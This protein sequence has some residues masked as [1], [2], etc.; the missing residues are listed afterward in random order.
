MDILVLGFKT[1]YANGKE[2]EW[3]QFTAKGAMNEVGHPMHSTWERVK[4]LIPTGETAEGGGG[5]SGAAMRANWAAIEPHYLAWK[6]GSEIPDTGTP[7]AAW[8]GVTADQAAALKRVGL[9]TVDDVAALP[10]ALLAKPPLPNMR[11]LQT[12]AKAYID[13]QGSAAMAETIAKQQAQIDA[14]LEMLAEQTKPDESTDEPE[15]RGPGRPRKEA[16]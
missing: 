12:M 7:L 1:D 14:M 11:E 8:S 6:E 9:R 16:A 4:V 13:G 5:L 2:T 3:V 10:E 15:K